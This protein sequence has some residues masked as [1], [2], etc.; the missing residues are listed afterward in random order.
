MD[1]RLTEVSNIWNLTQGYD[2]H[3]PD[4]DEEEFGRRSRTRQYRTHSVTPL[5]QRQ[6]LPRPMSRT[7]TPDPQRGRRQR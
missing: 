6:H 3:N 2:V 7:R 4:S 1:I 5:A